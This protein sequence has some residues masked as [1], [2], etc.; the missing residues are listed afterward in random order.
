MAKIILS[1]MVCLAM[2]GSMAY[3]A[4]GCSSPNGTAPVSGSCDAYIQ[5][6]NGVAEEKLC[7]DGL[8]YNEKSTGYPCGYPIE[9]ECS[10]PTAR[11][12]EAQATEECPHQFG[13]YQMGDS[14]NCGQFKNCAS[15]RGYIFDCPDGLAWNPET[16]KCDWPDLVE[17]CDA[18]AYLGFKCP[19]LPARSD[20]LGEPEQE[21]FFYPS[22]QNCQQYF[23]C[24]EGR[25]R[26]IS[27]D[28]DMAFNEELKQCDDIDNVPNCSPEIKQ[29]GA[30][31]KNA[32]LAAA[33]SKP[34]S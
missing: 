32:R 26:R 31:I 16:Y 15:G 8:L 22:P 4:G 14:K 11:L 23:L 20:L 17:A 30:E 5:C 25:P 9:V 18:E 19:P 1:A 27:C 13:Y 7:P 33:K 10:Q 34:R 24:V 12:Q 3:A 29:K 21:Y 6:T 28:G 2:F